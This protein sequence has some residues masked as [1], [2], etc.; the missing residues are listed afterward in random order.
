M[1][2]TASSLPVSGA[3]LALI[4]LYGISACKSSTVA[5][6]TACP[7]D[8]YTD[9]APASIASRQNPLETNEDNLDAG[10]ELYMGKASPVACV[11]CHGGRGDGNGVM[12]GMF[13]PPPRNF[14]CVQTMEQIPDGQIYWVIKNGSIG[15]SMPAFE[16]LS[17]E[18]VWQLTMYLRHLSRGEATSAV[19]R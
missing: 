3:L 6:S 15:T 5:R 18:Q 10:E 1:K 13:E 9:M 19:S 2:L 11:E 7:Q 4:C 16:K 14:T 12:A 17:D 8:R